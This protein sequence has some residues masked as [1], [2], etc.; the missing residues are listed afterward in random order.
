MQVVLFPNCLAV[1][2]APLPKAGIAWHLGFI[3]MF[4]VL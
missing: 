3:Q 2:M 1:A 4:L